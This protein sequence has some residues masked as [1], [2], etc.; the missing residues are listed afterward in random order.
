LQIWR[1]IVP[2]AALAFA[3]GT[4]FLDH[5]QRSWFS[6]EGFT[7]TLKKKKESCRG[8]GLVAGYDEPDNEPSVS[9]MPPELMSGRATTSLRVSGF[10]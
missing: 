2:R 1:T 6:Y 5:R 9:R 8:L 3:T 7:A 10:S 4:S